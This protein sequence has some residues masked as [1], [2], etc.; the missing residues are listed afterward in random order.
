MSVSEGTNSLTLAADVGNTTVCVG[1]FN[2]SSLVHFFRVK[3]E[4]SAEVEDYVLQFARQM[5][6]ITNVRA[7]IS[8]V[9]IGSVVPDLTAVIELAL[10]R[11]TSRSTY[12]VTH[13]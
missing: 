13:A 8:S 12:V 10:K 5:A 11:F 3:T 7:Q 1:L 2:R 6:G 9:V 4:P